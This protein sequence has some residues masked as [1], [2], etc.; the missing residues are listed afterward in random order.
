M[1]LGSTVGSI[2]ALGM[3]DSSNLVRH[4]L[5]EGFKLL[6]YVLEQYH[7]SVR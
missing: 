4:A 2:P 5:S 6:P 3:D 7:Q 1:K